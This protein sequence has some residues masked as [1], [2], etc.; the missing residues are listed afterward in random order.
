M[1]EK[2]LTSISEGE[3]T[4]RND[5]GMPIVFSKS[6]TNGSYE[7]QK[8]ASLQSPETEYGTIRGRIRG[9]SGCY[10]RR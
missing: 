6:G 3:V 1:K 2:A 9:Q 10:R 4:F 7:I 8:A 5:D